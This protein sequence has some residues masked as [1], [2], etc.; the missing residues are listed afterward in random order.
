MKRAILIGAALLAVSTPAFAAGIQVINKSKVDIDHLYISAPGKQTWGPDLLTGSPSAVLDA[1]K[2]YT[3]ANLAA[4]TYDLKLVD[5]DDGA[6]PCIVK[7]VKV[8]TG[9]AL[10]ITAKQTA[11]CK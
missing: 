2:T 5:D 4:G 10:K 3:V 1:G 9:A 11:S 8:K 7:G 6:A